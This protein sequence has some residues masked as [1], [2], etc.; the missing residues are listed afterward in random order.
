MISWLIYYSTK[1]THLISYYIF[2]GPYFLIQ[3]LAKFQAPR[4]QPSQRTTNFLKY[5]SHVH[6]FPTANGQGNDFRRRP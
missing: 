4:Q 5:R 3:T 6:L 1:K 2:S